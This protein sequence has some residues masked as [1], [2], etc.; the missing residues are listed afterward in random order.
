[1]ARKQ[2]SI[3]KC[4][5]IPSLVYPY[6]YCY[7]ACGVSSITQKPLCLCHYTS[8]VVWVKYLL[9][10]QNKTLYKRGHYT[11]IFHELYKHKCHNNCWLCPAIFTVLK[12]KN[13]HSCPFLVSGDIRPV[14]MH[15]FI[16]IVC[17]TC[18][19]KTQSCTLSCLKPTT[20][21]FIMCQCI[22]AYSNSG[23]DSVVKSFIFWNCNWK[24]R[25]KW[26]ILTSSRNCLYIKSKD[27]S[28]CWEPFYLFY[29]HIPEKV[30]GG[31]K[32]Q[33]SRKLTSKHSY[34]Y[35]TK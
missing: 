25:G 17:L 19:M 14:I 8:N 15:Y 7:I 26:F 6:Y 10:L 11:Y 35:A 2:I 12:K 32:S 22:L 18:A 16:F 23:H 29:T 28:F 33:T 20:L 4:L 21:Y 13:P 30:F 1:M 31:Q 3:S 9:L 34:N 24:F 27:E 5:T